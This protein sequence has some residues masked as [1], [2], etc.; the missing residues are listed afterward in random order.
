MAEI[1]VERSPVADFL[2]EL[3]SLILQYKQMQYAQQERALDREEKKVL[4]A[5]QVALREYYSKKEDIKA[6]E[7]MYDKYSRIS[8]SEITPGGADIINIIDKNNNIDMNAIDQNLDSLIDYE[9]DLK[10]GL[11]E[12]RMQGEI[13]TEMQSEYAG[14]N[15][16][17]QE[18]EYG[19]F[20]EH[21]LKAI[22]FFMNTN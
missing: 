19:A 12:I 7:A 18:H 9:T 13:L 6:T 1:V 3:P 20:R 16:V 10:R 11:N 15:L 14:A 4:Q 17:L 2:D 21:A 5:Q 22:V 8:P